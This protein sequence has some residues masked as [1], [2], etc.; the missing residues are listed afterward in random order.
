MTQAAASNAPDP[1][2]RPPAAEALAE[3]A[4][5]YFRAADGRLAAPARR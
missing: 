5:D 1:T 2:P 4:R 3:V